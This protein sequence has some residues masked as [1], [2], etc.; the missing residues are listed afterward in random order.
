MSLRKF[1]KASLLDKHEN[2]Q[3]QADK[4]ESKF[5]KIIKKTTKKK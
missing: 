4:G 5:L 3:A 1:R 2:A